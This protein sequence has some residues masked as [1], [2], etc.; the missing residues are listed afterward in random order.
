MIN[1]LQKSAKHLNRFDLETTFPPE[2]VCVVTGWG[3]IDP[4]GS[5]WGPVLKQ[6]YAQLYSNQE[7]GEVM[8]QPDWITDRM[9]CAGKQ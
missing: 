5:V 7:C 8:G 3:S 9:L 4:E 1:K 2:M 6:D